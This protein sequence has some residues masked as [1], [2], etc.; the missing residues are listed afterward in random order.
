MTTVKSFRCLRL[1]A[2]WSVVVP[3]SRRMLSPGFTRLA[4]KE[5]I[6]FFAFTFFESRSLKLNS[7][8][9]EVVISA[10]P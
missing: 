8:W 6:R 1:R 10:P 4:A 2:I 5:P 3:E 9:V 7:N